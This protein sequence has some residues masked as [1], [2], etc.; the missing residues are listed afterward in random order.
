MTSDEKECIESL[1]NPVTTEN[2]LMGWIDCAGTLLLVESVPELVKLVMSERYSI[3]TREHAART[4]KLLGSLDVS[5]FR[6][7]AT[8]ALNGLLDIIENK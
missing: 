3:A 2:D 8:P 7:D 1:R 6:Q 4:I 5:K